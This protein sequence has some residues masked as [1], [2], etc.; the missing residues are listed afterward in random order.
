MQL[1]IGSAYCKM[2]YEVQQLIH[3]VKL[4]LKYNA[5][6]MMH[7]ARCM[8]DRWMYV[9]MQSIR[10]LDRWMDA[11]MQSI[12]MLIE[13]WP[14]TNQQK[15][16]SKRKK[17]MEVGRHAHTHAHLL[18]NWPSRRRVWINNTSQLTN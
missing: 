8:Q 9:N 13:T 12:S 17:E 18:Q 1:E 2:A 5:V 7:R 11:N 6:S 16:V 4:E 10:M 14:K 3:V 15:Q